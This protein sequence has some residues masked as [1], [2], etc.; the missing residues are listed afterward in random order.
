MARDQA[1]RIERHP[2]LLAELPWW[3]K[4][5]QV[6][7]GHAV[8]DGVYGGRHISF[9]DGIL[10]DRPAPMDVRRAD[11]HVVHGGC[12]RLVF[13]GRIAAE[14][15]DDE[16]Q[17]GLPAEWLQRYHKNAFRLS[18]LVDGSNVVSRTSPRY[19]PRGTCASS[20]RRTATRCAGTFRGRS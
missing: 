9:L 5:E 14:A 11:R 19:S 3:V 10:K 16:L 8:T 6:H 4:K 17:N 7:Y 1:R 18:S 2:A 13:P 20:L 15:F 12:L